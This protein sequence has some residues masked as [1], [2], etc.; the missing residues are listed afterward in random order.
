MD[1]LYRA[2]RPLVFR[3]DPENAHKAAI[4]V[5]AMLPAGTPD[6]GTAGL[7]MTVAGIRFPNPVGLAAGFDK[8]AEAV[9]A[10]FRLGFGSVEAGTIT[11]LPQAGNPR[12][13]LFR[14]AEDRAVINRF[15]FNSQGG[16]A[17]EARLRRRLRRPGVVGINVGA[18]KESP[19]RIADY[20]A[21][22]RR[23]APL[24]SYITLNISS[25]NTPGLRALQ[26][27]NALADLIS[28]VEEGVAGTTTPIF[29]KIAPDLSDRELDAVARL[30]I[31]RRLGAVLIGNTTLS[32]PASLRSAH[33][34]E[35]GGLSGAPLRALAQD[36]LAT[37]YHASAGQVPL[38]GIGGIA[39][40]EHAWARIRAGASLIQLYSALVYEGPMLPRR[41]VAGLAELMRR[42]GFTDLAAAV[43][44]DVR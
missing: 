27:E 9:D 3:M 20:G 7:A 24:A 39:S 33:A 43:G 34:G 21:M 30:A 11:P 18:N 4:R 23:M 16:D 25:P 38:I 44:V 15:G 31:D 37:L 1:W 22:A 8:D 40:A 42:D 36:R 29:L 19:D 26:D 32:R 10:L 5:L 12:P 35:A 2:A 6:A 14:L 41:I 17:A 13:R 28:A